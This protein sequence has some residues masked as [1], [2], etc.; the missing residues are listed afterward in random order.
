M[1]PPAHQSDPTADEKEAREPGAAA[2]STPRHS[3][4]RFFAGTFALRWSADLWLLLAYTG[5]LPVN[6]VA[7]LALTGIAGASPSVTAF[8]LTWRESGPA[9]VRDLLGRAMRRRFAWKWY[10]LSVLLPLA[11]VYGGVWAY[12]FLSGWPPERWVLPALPAAL[13]AAVAPPLGEEFGW[14]GYALPRLQARSGALPASLVIGAAW[15]VW[16]LPLFLMPGGGEFHVPFIVFLVETGIGWSVLMTWLYNRSGGALLTSL[17]FHGAGNF[18]LTMAPL[19]VGTLHAYELYTAGL[20]L[21]VSLLAAFGHLTTPVRTVLR[22]RVRLGQ[23]PEPVP[24]AA[25]PG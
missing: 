21:L 19:Y 13:A 24:G 5:V 25:P 18:A 12:A 20:L 23:P 15:S 4:W 3:L 1:D 10:A 22:R 8:W 2:R 9:G 17:L 16:H 11:A 6:T 14:R 7:R